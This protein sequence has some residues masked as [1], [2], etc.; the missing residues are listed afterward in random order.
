MT[1][2]LNWLLFKNNGHI[3][4]PHNN[5]LAMLDKWLKSLKI[6]GRFLNNSA[7]QERF[8]DQLLKEETFLSN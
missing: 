6:I 5:L 3:F 7:N 8:N 2:N 1:V 4:C